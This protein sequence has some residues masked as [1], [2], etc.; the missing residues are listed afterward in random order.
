MAHHYERDD[1]GHLQASHVRADRTCA[2][3]CWPCRP[4]PTWRS[5]G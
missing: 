3:D 5:A 1:A 4:S 2:N